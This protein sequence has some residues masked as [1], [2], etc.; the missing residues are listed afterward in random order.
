MVVFKVVADLCTYMCIHLV[1]CQGTAGG[2]TKTQ[3]EITTWYSY[4]FI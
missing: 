2:I 1:G 3:V 4:V